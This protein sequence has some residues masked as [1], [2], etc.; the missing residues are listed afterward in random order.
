MELTG[1]LVESIQ[2][3][4]NSSWGER[5]AMLNKVFRVEGDGI[6]YTAGEGSKRSPGH[7]QEGNSAQPGKVGVQ[8]H[9]SSQRGR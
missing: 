2:S 5:G 6:Q 9:L 3:R 4:Q 1:R 7:E 8:T